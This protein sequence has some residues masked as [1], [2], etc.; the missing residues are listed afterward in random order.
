M[1]LARAWHFSTLR[2]DMAAS[3][4]EI[5]LRAHLRSHLAAQAPALTDEQIDAIFAK[6]HNPEQSPWVNYRRFARAIAATGK[7]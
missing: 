2:D 1:E 4:A 3:L 7:N 6:H 5:S